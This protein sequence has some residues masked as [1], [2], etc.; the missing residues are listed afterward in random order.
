MRRVL[1]LMVVAVMIAAAAQAVAG[2]IAVTKANFAADKPFPQFMNLWQ[3][4]WSLKDESGQPLQYAKPGMPLGG[5]VYVYFKNTSA[6]PARVTDLLIEGISI[7]KALA[8]TEDGIRDFYGSSIHVAKLP[9]A[10]FDRLIRAGEPLW[11][12]WDPKPVPPGGTG[13]IVL[14]MRR[15]AQTPALNITIQTDRG[16]AKAGISI[17]APSPR[18]LTISFSNNRD[19]VTAYVTPG[20]GATAPKK[21]LIDGRDVTAMS[22][23]AASPAS[24]AVPIVISLKQP[25]E[26]MSFHIFEAVYADGSKAAAGI[27]AWGHDMVYGMWGSQLGGKGSPRDNVRE[28][29]LDWSDH[30]I[31]AA[32]GMVGKETHEYVETDEGAE[33]LKTIGIEPVFGDINSKAK[34]L[35]FFLFD[36]PDANDFSIDDVPTLSK[37]GTLGQCLTAVADWFREKSPGIP[38]LLNIDNTWKPENWYVYHQLADIPCADPYYPE[39]LDF[40]YTGRPGNFGSHT[41]PTY[42]YA[43]TAISQSSCA[44]K[45]L[46]ILICSTKYRNPDYTGRF[47]TP[48]EARVQVYYAL[49]AGA[50]GLSYWWFSPDTVCYGVGADEPG[51]H[52]LWKEIGLLGAEVRTAGPLLTQSCPAALPV[53]ATRDVWV[54]TLLSGLDTVVLMAVNDNFLCDRLGTV[55]KATE[56]ARVSVTLPSWLRPVDAFEIGYDGVK[57][58]AWK[59]AG[60][61]TNLDLGTLQMTRMVVITADKGLRGRLQ[62]IYDRQFRE[63]VAGLLK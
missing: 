13:E 23:M 31:N 47:P 59:Q 22:R 41:K 37:L 34:P 12:K 43:V 40:S 55:V 3:E 57:D 15:K 17:A 11:W 39:Q 61:R 32:M 58:A 49:S 25:L 1:A 30:N 50:K 21:M 8:R 53:D 33:F 6:A 62:G 45:P 36:E 27:R 52:A 54:R 38:V 7:K 29:L 44:P 51:A 46:H 60:A 63:N 10:D 20:K 4:G 28:Y 5:Y 42:V 26:L 16:S 56:K 24:P 14:R 9:K 19:R 48:E 2:G 18:F 35:F